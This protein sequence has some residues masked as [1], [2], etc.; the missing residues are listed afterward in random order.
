MANWGWLPQPDNLAPIGDVFLCG[1]GLV[2]WGSFFAQFVLPVNKMEGRLKIIE[3]LLIYIQGSHGP[4]VF[5]EN[6]VVR[7]AEGETKKRGPGVIWLDSASAAVLRTPVKFTRVI[8]PGVHFTTAKEQIA[9]TV[10]LHTLTQT[11]GPDENDDPSSLAGEPANE[12]DKKKKE[13]LKKRCD[14]TRA[15]TRDNIEVFALITV[16]FRIRS[17]PGEGGSELGFDAENVRRAITENL[18]QGVAT[19]QPVWSPLPAKMAADV[20]RE[21]LRK[22]KLIELFEVAQG[23]N[24]TALKTIGDLLKKRLTQETV[25]HWDDYGR[26]P[27]ADTPKVPSQEYARLQE[28]GLEVTGV[29]IKRLTFSQ[30]VEGRLISQWTTQWLKNARKES[31]Q[32]ERN[33]KMAEVRAQEEALKDFALQASREIS[34]AGLDE[35]AKKTHALEMLVHS[36]FL[37]VRRNTLLLKRANAEQSALLDIFRWLREKRGETNNDI[38]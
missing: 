28:M 26:P 4:A 38:E 24:D 17:K 12:E 14:A 30:E 9:A 34:K 36:T 15:L 23:G 16:N 10:D 5:I 32:V 11:I 2:L 13:A 6:G 22:F 29:T 37:G 21:Y 35:A 8:G 31:E 18:L 7:A 33:R 27:A 19:D 20:W 3:Y 25:D 1:F